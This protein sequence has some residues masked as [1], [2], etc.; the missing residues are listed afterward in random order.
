MRHTLDRAP[1]IEIASR[2]E[3]RDYFS[4]KDVTAFRRRAG[5]VEN[6]HPALIV[7]VQKENR[8]IN[9]P[10]RGRPQRPVATHVPLKVAGAVGTESE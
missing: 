6:I 7:V 3:P 8:A 9:V 4:R 1:R 5:R 2:S 10:V